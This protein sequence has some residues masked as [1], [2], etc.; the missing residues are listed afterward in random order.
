MGFKE[1]EKNK[2]LGR[3]A[4]VPTGIGTGM[5]PNVST[6]CHHFTNPFGCQQ[7]IRNLFRKPANL[8][9]SRG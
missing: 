1:T 7:R 9:G 8:H 3:I 4:Y 6:E 2:N 5:F